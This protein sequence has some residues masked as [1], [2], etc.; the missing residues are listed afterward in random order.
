[1]GKLKAATRDTLKVDAREK[2]L[3]M[4]VIQEEA[5]K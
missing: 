5:K 3:W 4:S 2:H 1:M